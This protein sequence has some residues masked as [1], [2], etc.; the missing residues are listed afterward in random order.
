LGVPVSKFNA[1]AA[2][3]S[4][5]GTLDE[6][7]ASMWGTDDPI[8]LL[9]TINGTAH[10]FEIRNKYGV[11]LTSSNLEGP[12][13]PL[14]PSAISSI[15]FGTDYLGGSDRARE[16]GRELC[17]KFQSPPRGENPNPF[18]VAYPYKKWGNEVSTRGIV[19]RHERI[20]EIESGLEAISVDIERSTRI[21]DDIWRVSVDLHSMLAFQGTDIRPFNDTAGP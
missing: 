21:S 4:T 20:C 14:G 1:E 12:G 5:V 10:R 13:R 6:G 16:Y 15:R 9:V 17:E 3:K 7:P 18:R 19:D 11:Y 2:V 8:D